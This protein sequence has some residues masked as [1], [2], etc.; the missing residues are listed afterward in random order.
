MGTTGASWPFS[1]IFGSGSEEQQRLGW[2][3]Q[4]KLKMSQQV[5]RDVGAYHYGPFVMLVAQTTQARQMKVGR[6][7]RGAMRG[8]P[9]P[10][11]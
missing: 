8:A 4:T 9:A 6:R 11:H 3:A 2:P 10:L 7:R 5:P 1:T